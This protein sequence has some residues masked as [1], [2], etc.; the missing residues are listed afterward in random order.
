MFCLSSPKWYLVTPGEFFLKLIGLVE[1][2]LLL[3]G[4]LELSYERM[5]NNQ[6][7][8]VNAALR[9]VLRIWNRNFGRNPDRN[10]EPK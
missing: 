10:H 4:V 8:Y 2:W 6:L 3:A 5:E 7:F 1:P 9:A